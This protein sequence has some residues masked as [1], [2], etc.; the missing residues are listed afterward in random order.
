MQKIALI[1]SWLNEKVMNFMVE[2][3]YNA[4]SFKYGLKLRGK[5]RNVSLKKSAALRS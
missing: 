2:C 3:V 4:I 5:K 1:I